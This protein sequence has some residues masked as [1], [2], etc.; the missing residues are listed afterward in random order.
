MSKNA[1]H[2]WNIIVVNSTPYRAETCI[3]VSRIKLLEVD[4]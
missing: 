1:S 2:V 4:S 3:N